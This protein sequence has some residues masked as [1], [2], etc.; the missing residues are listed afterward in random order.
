MVQINEFLILILIS[1]SSRCRYQAAAGA[2]IKQLQV[3]ISSG[4][5]VVCRAVN[6]A[7]ASDSKKFF[8]DKPEVET[9]FDHH[10]SVDGV[11]VFQLDDVKFGQF[12]DLDVTLDHI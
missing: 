2:D 1:S 8:G 11:D 5:D 3:Q 4:F 7:H 12:N 9:P 6:T 10:L